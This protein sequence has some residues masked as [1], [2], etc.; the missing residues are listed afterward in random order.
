MDYWDE[1]GVPYPDD[2]HQVLCALVR[3][4][5]LSALA[6]HHAIEVVEIGT[7][8]NPIR[9]TVVDGVDVED[10]WYGDQDGPELTPTWVV[11][12]YEDIAKACGL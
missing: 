4:H 10:C 1:L 7:I 11:V 8:H 12:P 2:W 6:E 9:A 3:Q 5:L